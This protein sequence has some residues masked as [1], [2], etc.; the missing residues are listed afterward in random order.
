MQMDTCR[1]GGLER[2]RRLLIAAKFGEPVCPHAGGVGSCEYGQH[3]SFFDVRRVTAS[4][5]RRAWSE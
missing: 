1:L 3:V 2:R 5:D 4:P